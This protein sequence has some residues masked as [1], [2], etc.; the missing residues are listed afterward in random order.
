MDPRLETRE[1]RV[2]LMRELGIFT[3]AE[4]AIAMRYELDITAA[5]EIAYRLAAEKDR[6]ESERGEQT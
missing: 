6:P 1:G 3:D 5:Q 4:L 2:Q